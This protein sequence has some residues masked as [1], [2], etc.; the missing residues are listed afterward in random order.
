VFLA[1]ALPLKP[2]ITGRKPRLPA[3]RGFTARQAHLSAAGEAVETVSLLADRIA[4]KNIRFKMRDGLAHVEA[5]ELASGRRHEVPAQAVYLDFAAVFGE[6]LVIDA[7]SSGTAAAATQNEALEKALLEAIERDAL[8]VW[9]Y[10]R[11]SRAHL[12]PDLLREAKPFQDWLMKRARRFAL[13][14][15]STDVP[16]HAVA[17]VSWDAEG[18]AIA[19][20]SAAHPNLE[21]A[22][23][24]AASEMVQMEFGLGMARRAAQPDAVAWCET[25]TVD[26]F[27]Q[28]VPAVPFEQRSRMSVTAAQALEHAGFTPLAVNVS[29]ERSGLAVM[30]AIVPGLSGARARVLPERIMRLRRRFGWDSACRD[31]SDVETI[32]PY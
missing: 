27:V 31:A 30:R 25:V 32:D 1:A 8:S 13:I 12:D 18:R 14:D 24:A 22:C 15:I 17:A 5:M 4:A 7:D 23:L 21:R 19:L 2:G 20:G 26:S 16:V 9:W 3:G 28:F 6:R 29:E 10:G 11:H